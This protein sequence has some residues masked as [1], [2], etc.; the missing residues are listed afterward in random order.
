MTQAPPPAQELLDE[1]AAVGGR[2]LVTADHGNAEDMVRAARALPPS[3]PPAQACLS[4]GAP[5]LGASP[6]SAAWALRKLRSVQF[7]SA[8]RAP[9]QV[10]RDKKTGAPLREADGRP[11][12]L[13]SHTLNP[14]RGRLVPLPPRRALPLR[15]AAGRS[16]T[17]ARAR[18]GARG[19]WRPRPAGRRALPCGPAARGARQCGPHHPEP[20]RL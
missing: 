19:D 10:Q 14:V 18:A 6:V 15:A 20:A 12:P 9:A 2:W 8:P 17:A 1:V 7:A 16:P 13:S 5:G 11:R 3:A 4:A